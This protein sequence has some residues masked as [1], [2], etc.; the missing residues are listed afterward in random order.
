MSKLWKMLLGRSEKNNTQI[1]VAEDKCVLKRIE[2]LKDT[3]DASHRLRNMLLTDGT[4]I[5]K[6]EGTKINVTGKVR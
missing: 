4:Q 2:K 5:T 6:K 1:I 3:K